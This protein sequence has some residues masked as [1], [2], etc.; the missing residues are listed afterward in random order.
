MALEEKK[1]YLRSQLL[2]CKE[3]GLRVFISR[4][5]DYAY[6]LITDGTSI[7]YVQIESLSNLFTT[8]FQY[9]PSRKNGTGCCTMEQGCGYKQLTRKV[10]EE[11]VHHGKIQASKYHA[12]L[13][14]GIDQYLNDRWNKNN[15]MEL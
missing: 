12:T 5:E 8:T 14:T 1:K 2:N 6:G 11:A 15:Y 7:I 4:S 3:E 10:F 9:V 13:Y